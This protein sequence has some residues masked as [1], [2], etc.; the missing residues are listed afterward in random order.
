M[1]SSIR[2]IS[3]Q[4]S[5]KLIRASIWLLVHIHRKASAVPGAPRL[6]SHCAVAQLYIDL[7]GQPALAITRMQSPNKHKLSR[8]WLRYL[9][10][11]WEQRKEK[12]NGKSVKESAN[13]FPVV[14]VG[15]SI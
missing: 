14:W 5:L 6:M 7:S 8:G 2:A 12:K 10:I 9:C 4:V 13:D 11:C 1:S 3:C 15:V